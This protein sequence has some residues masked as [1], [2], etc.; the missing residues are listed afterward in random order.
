MAE[1]DSSGVNHYMVDLVVG[2]AWR[3]CVYF[4]TVFTI[5]QYLYIITTF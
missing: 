2:G 3:S 1:E 5:L 4:F